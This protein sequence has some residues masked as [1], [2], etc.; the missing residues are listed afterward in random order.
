MKNS[1]LKYNV[2]GVAKLRLSLR[3]TEDKVF[4]FEKKF[5]AQDKDHRGLF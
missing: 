2:T 4:L 3:G 1:V 5:M